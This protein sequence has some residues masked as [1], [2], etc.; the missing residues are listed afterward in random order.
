MRQPS[1]L[2]ILLVIILMSSLAG[3]AAQTMNIEP[4]IPNE[5]AKI[6]G[7]KPGSEPDGFDGIRWET[8]LSTLQGMKHYRTDPSHGGTEFYLKEN[9]TFKFGKGRLKTVQYGFW[10]GQFFVGMITTQGHSNWNALKEAVSEKYGE[11]AKPFLNREEFLWLGEDAVMA[12]R[13]DETTKGGLFYIRSES[14]LKRMAS[15]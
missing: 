2:N 7:F 1:K 12:L 9:N 14:M 3:C 15:E 4:N 11:G 5:N 13:Y 8:E 6:V 10:K